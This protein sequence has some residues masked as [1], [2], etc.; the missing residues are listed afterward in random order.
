[1][2]RHNLATWLLAEVML[3]AT[4]IASANLLSRLFVDGSGHMAPLA[5]AI[6]IGHGVLAVMRRLGF[7]GLMTVAASFIAIILA[8][9]ATHYP[10]T[11]I[12][13]LVATRATMDQVR[14]DFDQARELFS[15]L[16]A[17]V[18]A[19]TGFIVVSSLALW[20]LGAAADWSAF[21][22][23]APAQ[24]LVPLLAL[25]VFV[26]MLGVETAR[27]STTAIF[28]A[29]S[30]GFLISYRAADQANRGSWIAST[31]QSRYLSLVG[32]GA[33]LA[34]IAGI[35]GVTVG[36]DLPGAQE[37]PLVELND[38]G[39]R[40]TD[41]IEVISPLVQIQPRLV[42]QSDQIMFTVDSPQPA[43]WRIAALDVFDGQ[44]WRSQGKF[45]DADNRL[46]TESPPGIPVDQVEYLVN[47]IE[48]GAVWAP[49][50]YLPTSLQVLSDTGLSFEAE[51]ATFIVDTGS[52]RV[53]DGLQYRVTSAI[54]RPDAA[55]LRALSGGGE[56]PG[57]QYLELPPDF[58]AMAST[59]AVELTGAA[60]NDFDRALALQ[61]F[62]QNNFEYD[63]DVAAGHDITRT[64]DF[65]AVRRGYCEQFA[66]TF[67]AMARSLAIPARVAVGFTPGDTSDEAPNRY[68]VRGSHAHAWPEVWLG[69]AGWV[70]FEP[71]PG[72]G[73]P[74]A[75]YTGL[76]E[77]QAQPTPPPPIESEPEIEQ[78]AQPTLPP[79]DELIPEP[80]PVA[81]AGGVEVTGTPGSG[82]RAWVVPVVILMLL[83]T[84]GLG[85]PALKRLRD[86][87]RRG[88][89]PRR[90]VTL[91][92]SRAV[93]ALTE[94]DLAPDH[95]E[96]AIEYAT[97][98]A[99]A[100]PAV[101][102]ALSR[103]AE[104]V[105]HA[106][107]SPEAPGAAA[108]AQADQYYDAVTAGLRTLDP[109]PVRVARELD[110]RPLLVWPDPV[111]TRADRL[112]TGSQPEAA[113]GQDDERLPIL[114]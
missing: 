45:K 42:E 4:M 28:I 80:T 46:A 88:G 2:N 5:F 29:A 11:A 7:S 62:F 70:A 37:P 36:P 40:R 67:A 86:S 110:P 76:P 21:R 53:S 105:T 92:W 47:V 26:S 100:Q 109:V 15:T 75:A 69:K 78:A 1:M 39:T 77:Q 34:V 99:W 89:D 14:V 59:M 55:A 18:P 63:L 82:S 90:G 73:A 97:R 27:V 6:V 31:L 60:T 74:N 107:Y 96:T 113:V 104:M 111:A 50:A 61:N 54:A 48:M 84:W 79:N 41:P 83:L 101:E 93:Q 49:A 56:N 85:V 51:S 13:S 8:L 102:P 20:L 38:R 30:L 98:V 35:V 44:L 17:P 58:S 25:V 12:G 32:V 10:D 16:R 65:L 94:R 23:R 72:R 103:L 43:Y 81:P 108:V 68:E 9:T 71:T 22:L 57:D 87:T 95:D 114:N 64:D 106:A 112:A 24:A 33:A 3:V 66:S 19:A 52:Q 91:A